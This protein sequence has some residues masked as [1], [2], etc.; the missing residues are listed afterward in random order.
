MQVRD[1]AAPEQLRQSRIET[2]CTMAASLLSASERHMLMSLGKCP[3]S[4]D[5]LVASESIPQARPDPWNTPF[6]IRCPTE[7]GI[8]IRSGGPDAQLYSADDIV[9]GPPDSDCQL[10]A[11]E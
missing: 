1:D 11:T 4:V 9:L 3:H 2:A 7:H 8:E 6:D 10:P 5:D